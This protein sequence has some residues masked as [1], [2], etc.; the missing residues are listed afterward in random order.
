MGG[1][2]ITMMHREHMLNV[3]KRRIEPTLPVNMQSESQE[4]K[5]KPVFNPLLPDFTVPKALTHNMIVHSEPWEDRKLQISVFRWIWKSDATKRLRLSKKNAWLLISVFTCLCCAF[6]SCKDSNTN[7]C[8]FFC[9]LISL[10]FVV[11]RTKCRWANSAKRG[12]MKNVKAHLQETVQGTGYW[13][14]STSDYTL[15]ELIIT[16]R[17]EWRGGLKFLMSGFTRVYWP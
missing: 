15:Y 2:V 5:F 7:F 11:H 1:N 14:I 16:D 6:D 3:C 13:L 4:R 12:E 8:C 9:F 17:L 10:S